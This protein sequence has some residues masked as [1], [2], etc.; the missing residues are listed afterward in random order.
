MRQWPQRFHKIEHETV[1]AAE[2]AMEISDHRVEVG[3]DYL[4]TDK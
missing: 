4:R 2:L 1:A 3:P